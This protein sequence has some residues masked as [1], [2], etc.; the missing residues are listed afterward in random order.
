MFFFFLTGVPCIGTVVGDMARQRHRAV[1]VRSTM[2]RV[3]TNETGHELIF[4]ENTN[5][6]TEDVK[7]G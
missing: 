5:S 1:A 4:V 3:F 2:V 7:I 6:L